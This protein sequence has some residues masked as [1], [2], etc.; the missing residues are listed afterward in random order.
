MSLGFQ[1]NPAKGA[2]NLKKHKVS[3]TEASSVFADPLGRIFHDEEHSS[4]ERREILAGWSDRGRLLLVSFTEVAPGRIRIISARTA[5]R[6]E[7]GAHA[8]E[9]H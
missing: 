4:D 7:R 8:E 6:R 5:N 3:F 9:K 2:A 1:W